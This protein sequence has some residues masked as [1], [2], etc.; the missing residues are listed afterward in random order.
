LAGNSENSGKQG[1]S[2]EKMDKEKLTT[3]REAVPS[4]AREINHTQ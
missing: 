4:L 2:A 1:I 3:K